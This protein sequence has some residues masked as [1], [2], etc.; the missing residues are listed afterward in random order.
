VDEMILVNIVIEDELSGEIVKLILSEFGKRFQVNRIYPDLKREKASAGYSYIRRKISG[1]N[2]AAK[3][4]P[5]LVLTDLDRNECAPALI[6]EWLPHRQ[7]PNLLFRV[8]VRE[9]ENWV[10]ADRSSFAKFL[11]IESKLIPQDIDQKVPKPKKFLLELTVRSRKKDIKYAI[12]PRKGSTARVG[13]N[14]NDTLISFLRK[15]WRIQEA[16]KYSD[17]LKRMFRSLENFQPIYI[18]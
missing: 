14:Y 15:Y 18:N 17:S 4:T 3:V 2:N 9:V 5:Y 13:P 11:G 6:K 8:A 12:L 7:H 1:F 16:I 10:M